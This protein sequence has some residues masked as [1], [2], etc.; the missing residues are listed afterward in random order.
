MTTLKAKP[1]SLYILLCD[2]KIL[3]TGIAQ[4]PEARLIQHQSKKPPGAKFTRRF[5]Q[6]EIVYQVEVGTRSEAQSLEYHVKKLSRHRKLRLIQ[7][8]WKL[9]EL[10]EVMHL[11]N[12]A[13]E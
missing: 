1:Y 13:V 12:R 10:R 8:Q 4:D 9:S 6:L 11:T 7:E 2:S 5:N 3:Y